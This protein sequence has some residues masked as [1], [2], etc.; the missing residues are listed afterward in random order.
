MRKDGSKFWA[1]VVIDPIH[2]DDGK[3]A[4]FAKITRDITERREA[5]LALEKA[6]EVLFQSQKLEA[7]GKLTGGIAHDFNNLLSVITSGVDML[8]GLVK[9]PAAAALIDSMGKAAM[10]GANLT[11]QLLTFARQQ[12]LQ[13]APRDLN[14]VITCFE[15][16]LR[17]ASKSSV[18]FEVDV[19]A[20]CLRC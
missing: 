17:R 20:R 8:R 13:P 14:Q 9:E 12:P 2:T 6:R 19:S 1:H 11:N 5:A 15:G 16:V 18:K 7:I 3:M 4:G 10:R